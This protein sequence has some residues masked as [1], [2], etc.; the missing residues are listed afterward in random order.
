MNRNFPVL[1]PLLVMLI[2]ALPPG[3]SEAGS[4]NPP[5]YAEA[6]QKAI[7]YYEIQQA[8]KLPD[9]NRVPWRGDSTLNDGKKVGVDLSGGWF[10]AGDHMKFGFPMAAAATMLAWG[11]VEYPQAYQQSGQWQHLRN[12]LRFIADYFVAAHP[13]AEL[14]YGQV[15][16]SYNDHSRWGPAETLEASSSVAA[17]RPAYAIS[18]DCPGSDLAAETAAA[19]AAIAMVFEDDQPY[20]AGLIVHARELYQFATDYPGKYSDCITDARGSYKSWSGYIDELVWGAL[21]LYRATGEKSY[22]Q[23]AENNYRKLNNGSREKAWSWTHSWDDKSYGSYILLARLTGHPRYQTDVERWLDF[24]T[25]GYKGQRVHYSAGGLAQLD[26]WGSNRYTANTAW[27]ALLYS[28]W[29]KKRNISAERQQR[30]YR[31]ARSQLEYLLGNNPTGMSY[32][33]GYSNHSPINPH[34]RGSHGSWSNNIREPAVNRHP[35]IGALVGGPWLEDEYDDNRENYLANE[36]ATDY[37]AGFTSALARLYLDYG[38]TPLADNRFPP[39][40]IPDQEFRVTAHTKSKGPNHTDLITAI[41]NRSGW[42]ARHARNLTLR[43]FVNLK[44]EQSLGIRPVDIEVISDYGDAISTSQLQRWGKPGSNIWYTDIH[45]DEL[46]SA[47]TTGTVVL[48]AAFGFRIHNKTR[49]QLWDN[50]NDPSWSNFTNTPRTAPFVA[51]YEGKTLVWGQEPCPDNQTSCRPRLAT[52]APVQRTLATPQPRTTAILQSVSIKP[53]DETSA[54]P[55]CEYEITEEWHGGF[56]ANIRLVNNSPEPVQDWSIDWHF[57]DGS[58]ITNSW[59]ARQ[60]GLHRA[61]PLSWNRKIPPGG[62]V[63]VGVRGKTPGPDQPSVS[64]EFDSK[65]CSSI[66]IVQG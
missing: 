10:D 44:T 62:S 32:Q 55:A 58:A 37:N 4:T 41:E 34:H 31:F 43:Y 50:R 1:L 65:S 17:M 15:G 18:P 16:L 28:D 63:T 36:T 26:Q 23:Q 48:Q 52:Q 5:N 20:A 14:L 54:A 27:C 57:P 21:W 30:Y 49:Q 19:L 7:Y 46:Q 6:L 35:L 66:R 47:T 12:N 24:W 59:N 51:L 40:E 29:L 45:F 38:G 61:L 11:G 39:A 53:P 3:V 60:E 56:T 9:W 22:L 8:G 33:I 2:L 64:P 42:P 25:T 13:Q